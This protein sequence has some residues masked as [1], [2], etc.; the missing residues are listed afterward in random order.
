MKQSDHN[1]FT[2]LRAVFKDL[3]TIAMETDTDRTTRGVI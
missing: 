3:D 1:L 2:A